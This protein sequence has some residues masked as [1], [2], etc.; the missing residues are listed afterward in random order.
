MRG[1][2]KTKVLK[3]LKVFKTVTVRRSVG[4][5][6]SRSRGERAMILSQ[7]KIAGYSRALEGGELRHY[8]TAAA[9]AVHAAEQDRPARNCAGARDTTGSRTPSDRREDQRQQATPPADPLGGYLRRDRQRGEG[10]PKQIFFLYTR[11]FMLR[12]SLDQHETPRP[13]TPVCA[14]RV[15]LNGP[16]NSLYTRAQIWRRGKTAICGTIDQHPAK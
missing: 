3:V 14:V 1:V 4:R 10:H 11:G 2:K 7:Q 15:G 5:P 12:W 13:R 16:G 8:A 9:A 6:A